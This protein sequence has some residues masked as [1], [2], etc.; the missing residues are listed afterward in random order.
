MS[1]LEAPSDAILV[2]MDP[3]ERVTVGESK[4]SEHCGK[5]ISIVNALC[6]RESYTQ[7]SII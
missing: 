6:R 4:A 2:V 7:R 3:I 1:S 5:V